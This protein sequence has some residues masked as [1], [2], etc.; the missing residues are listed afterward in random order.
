MCHKIQFGKIKSKCEIK[1]QDP[2][3]NMKYIFED[4]SL[5]QLHPNRVYI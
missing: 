2:I 5:R 3:G 1:T 4:K